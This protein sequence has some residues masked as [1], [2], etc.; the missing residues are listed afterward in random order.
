MTTRQSGSV[1]A[2]R[3]R[4]VRKSRVEGSAQCRSSSTSTTGCDA[5]EPLDQREQRLE[6]AR[7]MAAVAVRDR[8]RSRRTPG[9]SSRERGAR[10]RR[11]RRRRSPSRVGQLASDR[12]QRVDQRRVG[13]RGAAQLQAVAD[14]DA[15]ARRMRARASSSATS[16][17]L[18]TPDSP[19]T[20]VNA[21]TPAAARPSAP[22]RAASSSARPTNVGEETRCSTASIVASRAASR[23]VLSGRTGKRA[24]HA[25]RGCGK[26]PGGGRRSG[27]GRA[28]GGCGRSLAWSSTSVRWRRRR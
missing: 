2:L 13:D 19:A 12:A 6:H 9:I 14:E 26:Q 20:N 24:G 5:P 4:K 23:E 15:G 17:L 1:R 22:S 16:R 18:P 8:G 27:C 7:L 3:T 21:G 10:G 28:S 25:A 11:Q